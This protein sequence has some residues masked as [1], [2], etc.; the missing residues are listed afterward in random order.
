MIDKGILFRFSLS[1]VVVN[2]VDVN[3]NILIF[4]GLYLVN[5]N[6]D[7]RVG[8]FVKCVVVIDKDKYLNLMY[9]F[10]NDKISY[11]VFCID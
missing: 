7:L 3:D 5:V 9:F 6:E 8:F 11:D 10:G 2:I 4:L 1:Y